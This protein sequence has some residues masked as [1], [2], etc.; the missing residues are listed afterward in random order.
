MNALWMVAAS[1]LFACM[2]VC[3]KL[4]GQYFAAG[5]LVF[6]RGFIAMLIIGGI[7]LASGVSLRTRHAGA[8]FWRSLAGFTSLV[9]YFYAITLI[10]LAT[11]V[12]LAYTS[13]LFLAVLTIWLV[14]EGHT[15]RLLPALALGFVGVVFVLQPTLDQ[16][17]WLGGLLGLTSG[18]ISS[19]A[20]FNVKRLGE[21]GEPEL[22]TVFYFSLFSCIGGLPWALTAPSSRDVPA[23]GWL[24]VVGIGAFG[25][26]AQWC[27]T[28]AYARGRTLVTASLAYS[29]V[30][31]SSL[32]GVLLWRE[33]LPPTAW[34]GIG[35]IVAAGTAATMLSAPR[36]PQP[37]AL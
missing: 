2:G 21:L 5:E 34:I 20:Y 36:R 1:L 37:T 8:H 25:A 24:L 32:A 31:F 27:M 16:R 7:V 19:I 6:F 17:Q 23:T 14:R 15:M 29:T 28:T 9:A 13:P 35:M 4:A 18:V 11:A 33:N 30:V 10:P 26:A 12:T 22:R 3:V